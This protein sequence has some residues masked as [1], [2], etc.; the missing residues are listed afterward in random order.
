MKK[1]FTICLFLL[2]CSAGAQ[3]FHW[4]RTGIYATS[5]PNIASGN[6]LIATCGGVV[7]AQGRVS[8]PFMLAV[9]DTLGNNLWSKSIFCRPGLSQNNHTPVVAVDNNH[10][11]IVAGNFRDSVFIGSR[12]YKAPALNGTMFFVA[13]F[14]TAGVMQWAR[15][16]TFTLSQNIS[17]VSTATDAAGNVYVSGIFS[18]T[19]SFGAT[20]IV[21]TGG[22]DAFL[23]KYDPNGNFIWAQKTGTPD[24]E[25]QVKTTVTSNGETYLTAGSSVSG[26]NNSIK[27]LLSKFDANGTLLFSRIII[28]NGNSNINLGTDNANNL[29]ISGNYTGSLDFTAGFSLTS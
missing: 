13:K 10:N 6:N 14:N 29:Y 12:I 24:N 17:S 9:Q 3:H 20:S 2:A 5:G 22:I 25:N 26:T 23:I 1:L 4:V 21:A 18:G 28:P 7:P 11:V 15:N 8:V 16:S 19:L 27:H